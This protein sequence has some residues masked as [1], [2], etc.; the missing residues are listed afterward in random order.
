MDLFGFGIGPQITGTIA[1]L[2]ASQ[3]YFWPFAPA[4]RGEQRSWRWQGW[5]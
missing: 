4:P 1:I 3:R 5:Y 2:P